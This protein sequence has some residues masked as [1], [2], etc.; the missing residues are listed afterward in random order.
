MYR[1]IAG[2][3]SRSAPLSVLRVVC[4]VPRAP[5]RLKSDAINVPIALK[6]PTTVQLPTALA[7]TLVDDYA[8]MKVDTLAVQK[9]LKEET[10]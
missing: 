6:K 4:A 5:S 2:A 3:L 7:R 1:L 9:Q 10:K 8:W